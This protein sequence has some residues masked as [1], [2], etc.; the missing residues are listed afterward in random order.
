MYKRQAL[1]GKDGL[2]LYRDPSGLLDLYY[3]TGRDGQITVSSHLD[4]LL[5]EPGLERRLVRPSLHEYLRFGDIAAPHTIFAGA[6]AVEAGQLLRWTP[7]G[8]EAS[9]VPGNEPETESPAD[10]TAAV[11][12]LDGYLQ[13]SLQVR[14]AD[15]SRPAAFLSGGI[16]SALIC[17]LASRQRPDTTAVTV[18]F[19]GAAHD[20]APVAGRIAAHLGL[21]HEVL[22]FS[23]N[24]YLDAFGRLTRHLEQP[25]ADPATPA[26]VLAFDHCRLHFDAVL[27]GTGADE[28]AGAMPPRHVRLAVEY[29]SLLPPALRRGLVHGKMCIRDRHHHD[30][31][32]H[33]R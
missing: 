16:D 4:T 18:G 27:D 26:T 23:R 7:A 25:I 19:D 24:Q 15:T 10:F 1:Y 6:R 2:A 33:H 29:G 20:E 5:R 30:Q 17:A 12:A 22:R 21:R 3:C 28:A 31:P 14:L 32:G 8:M 9:P 11:D 13:R